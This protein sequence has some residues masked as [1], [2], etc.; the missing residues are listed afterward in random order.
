[1][2][3]AIENMP[4]VRIH[5][6]IPRHFPCTVGT[7]KNLLLRTLAWLSRPCSMWWGRGYKSLVHYDLYIHT[8]QIK[9]KKCCSDRE[10]LMCVFVMM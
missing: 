6:S 5:M 4:V 1:M 2:L 10:T 8:F 9:T 7:I 3:F